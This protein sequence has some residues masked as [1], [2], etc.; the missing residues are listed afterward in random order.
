MSCWHGWPPFWPQNLHDGSN[1]ITNMK[2]ALL[3]IDVQHGLFACKFNDL[4]RPFE[5]EINIVKCD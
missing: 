3:I 1:T 4:P 5:A 2:T